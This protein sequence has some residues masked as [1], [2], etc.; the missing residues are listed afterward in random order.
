MP[1]S[2]SST[3]SGLGWWVYKSAYHCARRASAG[4]DARAIQAEVAAAAHATETTVVGRQ[5]GAPDTTKNEN[6]FGRSLGTTRL[7]LVPLH[8]VEPAEAKKISDLRRI[9][10]CAEMCGVPEMD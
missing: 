4:L 9:Q 1:G 5:G 8:P 7:S 6:P 3:A 10:K 2:Q